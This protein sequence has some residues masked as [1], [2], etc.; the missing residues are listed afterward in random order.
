VYVKKIFGS[1][2]VLGQYK[3]IQC[4]TGMYDK[5]RCTHIYTYYEINFL[6]SF[7]E[8]KL[9]G[10]VVTAKGVRSGSQVQ[11]QVEVWG[12]SHSSVQL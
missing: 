7:G 6:F 9:L 3:I 1:T 8:I 4:D 12:Q 10:G 11:V 2:V 5:S